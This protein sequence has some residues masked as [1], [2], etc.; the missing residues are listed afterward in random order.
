MLFLDGGYVECRNGS[1]TFRWGGKAPTGAALTALASRIASRAGRFLQRQGLLV[2]DAESAVNSRANGVTDSRPN[3]ASAKWLF[4]VSN[5][6][7]A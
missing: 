3:E 1:L 2:R 5:R 7:A 4:M 6:L